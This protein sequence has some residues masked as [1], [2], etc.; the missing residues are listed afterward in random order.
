MTVLT[1]SGHLG[2][3]ATLSWIRRLLEKISSTDAWKAIPNAFF[4]KYVVGNYYVHGMTFCCLLR[5]K[6][7]TCLPVKS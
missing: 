7:P 4:A 5:G 3:D 2:W 1:R 6:W